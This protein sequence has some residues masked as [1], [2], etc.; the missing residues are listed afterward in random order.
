LESV[1]D[2]KD[3]AT[4]EYTVVP[5]DSFDSISKKVGTTIPA[6]QQLNPT[7]KV[8]HAKDVIKYRKAA[9]K[10]VLKGWLAF[11]TKNMAQRYNVGDQNYAA[12]LDYCLAVMAKLKR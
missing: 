8:L 1:F 2:A 5:G 7:A 9:I 4:H 3:T 11:N 10:R 6:L 12:K